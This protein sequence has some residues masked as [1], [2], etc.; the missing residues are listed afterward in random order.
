NNN[1]CRID[2]KTYT[3]TQ[4]GFARHNEFMTHQL[5]DTCVEFELTPNE[6]ILKQ[7]PYLFDLKVIYTLNQNQ[8]ECHCI[9]RNTD[10]KTIYFQI[11]GHPAF[12]CPFMEN[13]SSNEYY[14]E[15]EKDETLDQKIINV[16]ERGM[17]H[18]T[19]Q[20]F[21]HERRFF[22]RQ[23]LFNN[24]AVVVKNF[25]SKWVAL[26]SIH[27][28]KSI[29][30]YMENFEHLGIWAAKHVGGLIAIEPWVGHNDYVGFTGEFKEK[31]SI[32]ALPQNQEFECKF[33]VEINQ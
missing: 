10:S 20:L 13:E 15:F 24:D 16:E 22:I 4:H 8:L 33:T 19:K 23:A 14:I 7:Y 27:H 1:E 30:F 12:A 31:E 2:G 21:D 18:E 11:G 29:K 5:S 6:D 26:K 28:Q 25:Q 3:M 17:S 9:V 32:V